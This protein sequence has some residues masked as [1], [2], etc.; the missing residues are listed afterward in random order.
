MRVPLEWLK[1]FVEIDASAEQIAAKLTMGGLEVEGI[2]TSGL[3]PVIDVYVTPNRGDCL[4]ILGV[5]RE[6]SAL[7][8]VPLRGVH[9]TPSQGGGAVALLT[10]VTL[11]APEL[12][13]R[14]AARIL[15]NV[16]IGPTPDWMIQ[17]LQATVGL[18][19]R[20]VNN[21]VDV[22]NYVMLEMGQPL[23]AFDFDRLAGGRIIV[24]TA[25]QGESITTLDG[26]ERALSPEMLVIADAEKPVAIAGIMGGSETEISP[27]TSRIL[28]ES[29]HFAPLSIRRTSRALGLRTEASYRYERVVDPDLARR[30]VDRACDLLAQMGLTGASEGVIDQYP[31]PT[32]ER[33][34]DLRVERASALLGMELSGHI[35][36][37]A[38]RALGFEVETGSS[39]V[40]DVLSV[41]APT[42]RSDVTI[43][44][45]LVEEVGRIHGFENIPEALPCGA[46]TQGGD[47]A[48]GAFITKV[49][50]SLVSGGLQEVITHSLTPPSRLDGPDS[51]ERRVPVR[52]ALS[53]EV[54]G[55]RR[56]LLPGLVAA[57][58]HN[59]RYGAHSLALFEVGRV[60][61]NEPS[62]GEVRPTEYLAVAGLLMGRL[63]EAGWRK[64]LSSEPADFYAA[65][66]VVERL[67]ADLGAQGL[68]FRP[69]EARASE[70]PQFHPGRTATIGL[71]G[72]APEGILG[73]IHPGVAA[74][75]G[76]RE[77]VYLFE[78]S[79]EGLRAAA[80]ETDRQFRPISRFPAITRDLA[81]RTP[82]GVEYA[83]VANVVRAEGGE[84]LEEF[85]LVDLFRGEPLPEGT[86]SLTLSLSFRSPDHTLGETEVEEA[87]KRMR[88]A[89]SDRCQATF[90]GGPG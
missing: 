62:A 32:G 87:L 71:R 55:L 29:A 84:L 19:F 23:H 27:S 76:L 28:I 57:A 9:P 79:L 30:A 1:E 75:L 6:V 8:G 7:Y 86:Q 5:A 61:Q 14:Y 47:S 31:H 2:E 10:S 85:R 80:S 60:W 77:R 82:V 41:V 12:C 26:K 63:G 34:L 15:T 88:G 90:A 25:S 70:L 64:E 83:E 58:Q 46:T 52:N 44:E 45:D 38:L 39:G 74:E 53:A 4:S 59:G 56:S 67:A 89:L 18:E 13:P 54:G 33:R 51:A 11:E 36:A 68:T 48:L 49:K 35:C 65:R 73:E 50:R 81:P 3:G 69:L 22:T 66:G 43:E 16:K 20:S 72:G 40:H 17:R 21:V 24:R 42:F 37:D 78:L